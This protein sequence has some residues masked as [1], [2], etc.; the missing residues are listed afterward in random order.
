MTN[1]NKLPVEKN[2]QPQDIGMHYCNHGQAYS[3]NC[4]VLVKDGQRF[5]QNHQQLCCVCGEP[6]TCECNHV[7]QFVCG[8]TIKTSLT[9][10]YPHDLTHPPKLRMI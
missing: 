5:C 3:D 2:M 7:G 9:K 6:S 10:I 4:K 8:A 1:N